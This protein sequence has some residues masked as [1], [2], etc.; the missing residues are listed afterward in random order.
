MDKTEM[1]KKH[2][3]KKNYQTKTMVLIYIYIKKKI[4]KN[5]KKK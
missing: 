3:I 2:R 5:F 1:Q 4:K